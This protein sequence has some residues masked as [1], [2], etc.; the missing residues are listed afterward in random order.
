MSPSIL[1][2]CALLAVAFACAARAQSNFNVASGDWA[3][4]ANWNL[5]TGPGGPSL[6]I[7]RVNNGGHATI[8]GAVNSVTDVTVGGTTLGSSGTVTQSAGTLTATGAGYIGV[9]GATGTYNL[10][11]GTLALSTS[12]QHLHVGATTSGSSTGLGL[13]NVNGG[14]LSLPAGS[15][16]RVGFT[17]GSGATSTGTFT[18]A[19]GRASV[20]TL[21][22][23]ADP[24][25]VGWYEQ[26]GGTFT[27]T[28]PGVS[29]AGR[30]TSTP[31]AAST[32]EGTFKLSGGTFIV[33]GSGNTFNLGRHG[34]GWGEI[35]GTG[36]LQDAGLFRLGYNSGGDGTLNMSGGTVTIGNNAWVGV[37]DANS[38]A[39]ASDSVGVMN[40]SGGSFTTSLELALG[41]KSIV[42]G[43]SFTGKGIWNQTG[44]SL[45]VGTTL[46]VG[47]NRGGAGTINLD[48]GSIT[49]NGS[50]FIG[51]NNSATA[52]FSDLLGVVNQ[53][54]GTFTSVGDVNIGVEST[55][56]TTA[57]TARGTWNITGGTLQVNG[58]RLSLGGQTSNDLGSGTVVISGAGIVAA[59]TVNIWD[60]SSGVQLNGGVLRVNALRNDGGAFA[61]GAG[62]ITR[63]H[64]F[65]VSV[66]NG[67]S[68]FS[69]SSTQTSVRLGTLVDVTGTTPNLTTSSGSE[70]DV[71]SLYLNLGARQDVFS[72]AGGTLNLASSGDVLTA[73]GNVYL[74]RGHQ[75]GTQEYGSIPLVYA[76]SITGTFDTFNGGHDDSRGFTLLPTQV[77]GAL[78]DP[79][80]FANDTGQ[81]QYADNVS[82]PFGL[83][84]G[85]YDVLYF[86]Y[87]VSASVPEP[88]TFLTLLGSLGLLRTARRL[89]RLSARCTYR[90]G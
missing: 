3:T 20:G 13:F 35:S 50:S 80:T 86:H 72:I 22:V 66:D 59:P 70:L 24:G 67:A 78:L 48:G 47:Q 46:R 56:E 68:D 19:S 12:G 49:V 14:T 88:A 60:N 28:G 87:K 61:W 29:I 7:A 58:N 74:L 51:N 4:G 23:G 79:S 65:G 63:Y 45:T 27:T 36:V 38:P 89:R 5:P 90:E 71:G 30:A 33:S 85:T 16:L 6:T 40:L 83:P 81:L 53:T 17:G 32:G 25:A 77:G 1:V 55:S 9:N 26:T 21:R 39:M 11:G 37:Q 10:N 31:L 75:F 8:S 44:G 69:P 18:L 43:S 2:R 41:N 76:N 54:G 62:K 42:E 84:A 82:N 34:T 64:Q 73:L 57:F 52:S 15:D